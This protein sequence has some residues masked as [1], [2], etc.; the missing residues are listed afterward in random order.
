M[1]NLIEFYLKILEKMKQGRRTIS[2]EDCKSILKELEEKD[3]KKA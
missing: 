3:D 2:E 1:A